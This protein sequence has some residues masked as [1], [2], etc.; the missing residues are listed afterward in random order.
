[1]KEHVCKCG[2]NAVLENGLDG[3]ACEIVNS[4][5][6]HTEFGRGFDSRVK[7]TCPKCGRV[8][9]YLDGYP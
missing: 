6:T 5:E 1:M 7:C 3:G 8:F 9:E 4:R 2:W